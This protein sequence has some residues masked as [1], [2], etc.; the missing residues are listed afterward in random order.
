MEAQVWLAA[1]PPGARAGQLGPAEQLGQL[2]AAVEAAGRAGARRRAPT[3]ESLPYAV[4][5][6]ITNSR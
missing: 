4:L 2:R 1:K 5:A 3:V 6:N